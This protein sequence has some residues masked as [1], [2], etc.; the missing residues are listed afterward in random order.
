M[1]NVQYLKVWVAPGASKERVEETQKGLHISVREPASNNRAN[2]RVRELI[3]AHFG[4]SLARV[5]LT[6]GHQSRSKM[7]SIRHDAKN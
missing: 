6:H 5:R 3:A 2:T 1:E 7:Y 4:V